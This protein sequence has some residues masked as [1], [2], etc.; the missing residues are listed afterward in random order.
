M[1]SVERFFSRSCLQ[2]DPA[3]HH[4]VPAPLVEL[5]DLEVV[6]IADQVLDVGHAPE[7][8]LRAREEGV[9]PHDVHRDAA[10]DLAGQQPLHGTVVVVGVADELPHAQEVRLLL[11]QNHH[12]VVVLE[13]LEEYFD[14][15]SSLHG[16]GI[17]E[18][19]DGNRAFALESE[20][21][22]DR[23]VGGPQHPGLD[24]LAFLDV[25]AGCLVAREHGLEVVT[26]DIE[27]LFAV[28]IVEEFGR[29][30]VR[31][32]AQPGFGLGRIARVVRIRRRSLNL[33]HGCASPA[34]DRR[35]RYLFRPGGM[36]V[37]R[38]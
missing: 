7:R 23:R 6:A 17:L 24:Y 5:D 8:D 13:A 38:S 14:F 21:K 16:G 30:L 34:H 22:D 9:H 37:G 2:D 32:I 10:L 4:D 11:G 12:A 25:A 19:L 35:S 26:R 1:T 27:L 15:L 29:D 20:F 31:C 28:R 18:F 36:R 33:V 3:G